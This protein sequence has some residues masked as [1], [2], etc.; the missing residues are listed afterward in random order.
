[1]KLYFY[2]TIPWGLKYIWKI[3]FLSFFCGDKGSVIY[4]YEETIAKSC[5]CMFMSGYCVLII[6]GL[7]LALLLQM[8]RK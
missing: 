1:M 4:A 5:L 3:H 8:S 7:S 2:K 6:Q